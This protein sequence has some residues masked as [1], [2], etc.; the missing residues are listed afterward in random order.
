[1]NR[2]HECLSKSDQAVIDLDKWQ[3]TADLMAEL[4]DAS[5]GAIVQLHDGQFNVI[6]TSGNEDNFLSQND[7]WSWNITSFCRYMIEN[8]TDLYINKAIEHEYWRNV[9]PV[10]EGQVRSYCGVPLYWPDGTPFGSICVID[11]KETS[12]NVTMSRLLEQLAR[13]ITSDLKMFEDFQALQDL[14]LTD[15]LTN[16][17][18]RRGLSILGEQKL[19]DAKRYQS[20]VG[21]IYLDIDNM[22]PVNDKFGHHAGDDC[23][24]T[25]TNVLKE[26]CR[27][28]DVI[29][30]VGGD[31]FIVITQIGSRLELSSLAARVEQKYAEM[32]RGNTRLE[33]S[34]VS[35]G[36]S[37][38]DCYSSLPFNELLAEADRNMYQ[39]KKNKRR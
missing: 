23:I 36:T 39:H 17:L 8:D 16:V 22:K 35:Y 25:L 10:A 12:Y 32:V 13:L 7:S 30:R 15:E 9:P 14:A 2:E 20:S 26:N 37:V 11:T 31:E 1:M 33:L 28:N 29:A 19:K 5:C 18:N 3:Q 4:F 38:I 6:K 34:A 27:E 24:V 21:V